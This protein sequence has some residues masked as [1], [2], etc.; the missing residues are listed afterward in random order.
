[1]DQET[2]V[3]ENFP[4]FL[5]PRKPAK[6]PAPPVTAV[7][8]ANP[9]SHTVQLEKPGAMNSDPTA[10]TTFEELGLAEWAVK[11]CKELR[12]RKPRRVQSHCIPRILE[13]RHVLGIDET[14]SG[15]T[16]AFALP[17]LQRLSEH[18]YGVFALVL[19][20]TRELAYQLAEQFRALGSCLHLRL[21]VVVGGMDMLKQAKSLMSRPH[22]VIATPGRIK[23]LLEENPDI[24][25][26]FSRIKF[27]VLDE[28]DRL[29]D[30]GFQ[31][32]LKFLFQCLP[33]NRQNLF[34]SATTTS[35]LQKLH[36]RYQDK[37][38][39]YEAYEGFKTVETLQ[40]QMIFI[41][42]KVKEVYLTH[43]LTKMDDMSVR[44]TIIFV[45]TC[46]DCHRLSLMLDV[47]EVEAASLYSFKSQ[48]ERLK[49]LHEFKAGKVSILL[50]TDVASRGLDIPTVDLV[51]N[52]DVPRFPRDYVH[53]VGRTAR[54]G[55]GGLALSIVTQND[56]ELIHE[57]EALLERQLEMI[58]YKE[59]EVLSLIKK[60]F[61]AKNVAEMKMMDDGFEEK[62]KERKKQKLEMLEAKGL[63]KKRSKKRKRNRDS[64]KKEA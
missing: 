19:T 47:I 44:S 51:I 26:V 12:M 2:L 8:T 20:P 5:K 15:K 60:A 48:S 17:I 3:D 13:G 62:E 23:V 25:P 7:D 24:P 61:S 57:I 30:V 16:A 40:Q 52:Y 37:L 63:L 39:V 29:L 56:I 21:T 41:P 36:E 38:Y 46:R 64:E 59:T 42:K 9:N 32:E 33:E 55:R 49:A 34:F 27:L 14:G 28:A 53:R 58:E 10:A 11:T 4:L 54:A 35:N 1:M 6:N 22:I 45:N 43:V 50:A 18:P 31:E